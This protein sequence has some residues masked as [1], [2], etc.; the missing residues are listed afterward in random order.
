MYRPTVVRLGDDLE[1]RHDHSDEA[2]GGEGLLL[3]P[4]AGFIK[5][6]TRTSNSLVSAPRSRQARALSLSL[7]VRKHCVRHATHAHRKP[8]PAVS[9]VAS[10]FFFFFSRQIKRG[11][12][13]V[14]V[15]HAAT[16]EALAPGLH[17]AHA[18]STEHK[19][20]THYGRTTSYNPSPGPTM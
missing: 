6:T 16:R 15:Q 10:F 18:Q 11:S 5:T 13:T 20:H 7:V 1:V 3:V 19:G 4:A 12:K 2:L 9:A 14:A 17:E 8:P